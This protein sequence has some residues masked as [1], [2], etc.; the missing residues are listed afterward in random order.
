MKD[1]IEANTS[2]SI[3]GKIST[4]SLRELREEL[5]NNQ[6]RPATKSNYHTIWRNFNKFLICLDNMPQTWEER[7]SLYCTFI[8]K[9][10]DIQSSTLR[11]HESAIKSKVT[12]DGYKWNDEAVCLAAL[13]GSCK[14]SN[15][16]VL[17]R[18]P[19]GKSLLAQI[20][21]EINQK[22]WSKDFETIYLKIMYTTGF[23]MGYYGMMRIGEFTCSEHVAKAKDVHKARQGNKILIIL[24]SS[25]THRLDPRPQEI[26]IS[27]DNKNESFC[28][29]QEINKYLDIRP[30]YRSDTEQFLVFRDN[31]PVH[32]YHIRKLLK[33]VLA[34]LNLNPDLYDTHSLR[35][36]RAT[37]LQKEKKGIETIKSAGRWSSNAVYNYLRDKF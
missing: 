22:Y 8:T 1:T 34:E 19:I 18:L 13:V 37:D 4:D 7:T 15:D 11:S 14:L 3:D 23:I 6:H 17:T 32:P 30:P 24:Y 27:P 16:R 31:S 33:E 26:K 12:S 25:K 9:N 2:N 10:S 20:T 35:I 21:F 28:P 5:K 29:V 36:G